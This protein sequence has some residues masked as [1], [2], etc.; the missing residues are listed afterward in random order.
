MND[1]NVMPTFGL[2]TY[3]LDNKDVI[4]AGVK[5]VLDSVRINTPEK[6]REVRRGLY[7]LFGCL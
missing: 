1:G 5:D 6:V 3:H 7:V 4:K 2:G